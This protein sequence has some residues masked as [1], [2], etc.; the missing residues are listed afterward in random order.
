MV[1]S[2]P[3]ATVGV[4]IANLI[5]LFLWTP[6]V[7][8]AWCWKSNGKQPAVS[9]EGEAN[10]VLNDDTFVQSSSSSYY[11]SH[12]NECCDKPGGTTPSHYCFQLSQ[13]SDSNLLLVHDDSLASIRKQ[14]TV[15][16]CPNATAISS[17]QSVV[18]QATS[19]V[20]LNQIRAGADGWLASDA[21]TPAPALPSCSAP[22]SRYL[23]GATSQSPQVC[24]N[25]NN[26][27]CG[28][29]HSGTACHFVE[30]RQATECP[31]S[32]ASYSTA[33]TTSDTKSVC[34]DQTSQVCSSEQGSAC[35]N[36]GSIE[37]IQKLAEVSTT[38]DVV[39][40]TVGTVD[41]KLDITTPG[42]SLQPPAGGWPIL[43]YIHG[44][45]WKTGNK[46]GS[47]EGEG[48]PV[49]DR[50]RRGDFAVVDITYRLSSQHAQFVGSSVTA[51]AQIEDV[52]DAVRFF[53]NTD[54]TSTTRSKTFRLDGTRV[55][56][57][58][59][60]A[61][62][63][64]CA[65]LATF[66]TSQCGVHM[67]AALDVSGP[68]NLLT[69]DSDKLKCE[70]KEGGM[71]HSQSASA[72]SL[73]FSH[74][75]GD[76]LSQVTIDEDTETI[77]PNAGAAAP[78]PCLA[79]VANIFNPVR[80]VNVTTTPP[81]YILHPKE[82]HM[83]SCG[84]G[85]RL[86]QRLQSKAVRSERP[87]TAG[88]HCNG[89]DVSEDEPAYDWLSNFLNGRD[90]GGHY[91]GQN[92]LVWTTAA[93]GIMDECL[94]SLQQGFTTCD[95]AGADGW[96][97]PSSAPAT[98]APPTPGETASPTTAPTAVPTADP[99]LTPTAAPTAAPT[100]VPTADPTFTPTSAAPTDAPTP[101]PPG[102][103]T[104]S[105]GLNQIRS[106]RFL[107]ASLMQQSSGEDRVYQKNTEAL[108]REDPERNEL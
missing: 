35:T 25:E 41:L 60:S 34:F 79:H 46:G 6:T 44:G 32:C 7:K 50:V 18:D 12:M 39:Y 55:A 2:L 17:A 92:N 14:G 9:E 70:S 13:C 3:L 103:A 48:K 11:T 49:L 66:G 30:C 100:A 106:H 29:L 51:P 88:K 104:S 85:V 89:Y 56:C 52:I 91:S 42:T 22:C 95:A 1:N 59:C 77:T 65:L 24:Q 64:L 107:S 53:Q 10:I 90:M 54:G 40:K 82:D 76:I 15:G 98:P 36:S 101:L 80:W 16:T 67:K 71:Q 75:V 68:T 84:Q 99:T 20:K 47:L 8:S 45:G 105:L 4:C 102:N 63:H 33:A 78:Y 38:T 26:K 19:S 86:Y 93:H 74:T 28:R 94:S 69:M 62:G 96:L 57:K 61:G 108:S 5:P 97:V 27:I 83:V 58:G 23:G 81:T 37:C 31:S 21:P 43:F 87:V 72:E 73:V